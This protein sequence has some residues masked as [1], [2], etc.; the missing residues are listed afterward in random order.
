MLDRAQQRGPEEGVVGDDDQAV[1][2]SERGQGVDV[3][4]AEPGVGRG[5]E[6]QHLGSRRDR[7]LDRQQVRHVDGRHADAAPREVVLEQHPG[8]HEQLVADDDVIALPEMREQ[9]R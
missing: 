5:L 8:D 7:R 4:D 9:R 1:P 2:V 3:G 6:E